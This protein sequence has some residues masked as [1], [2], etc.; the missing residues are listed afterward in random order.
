MNAQ[1]ASATSKMDQAV[2]RGPIV[3]LLLLLVQLEQG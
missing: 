2:S 1:T 3:G